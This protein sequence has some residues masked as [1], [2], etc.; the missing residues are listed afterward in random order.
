MWCTRCQVDRIAGYVLQVFDI[1]VCG[2]VV[3][4]ALEIKQLFTHKF[5]CEALG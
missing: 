4:Q 1:L 2:S 5:S 3:E